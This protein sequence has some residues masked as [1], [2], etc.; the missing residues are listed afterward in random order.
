MYRILN[1]ATERPQMDWKTLHMWFVNMIY[2]LVSLSSL[3]LA[4]PGEEES[5]V[6]WR[7]ALSRQL[8]VRGCQQHSWVTHSRMQLA[9][10]ALLLQLSHCPFK[11]VAEE[12]LMERGMGVIHCIW[13]RWTCKF[14]CCLCW[15]YDDIQEICETVTSLKNCWYVTIQP[16]FLSVAVY[17][18]I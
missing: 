13:N 4:A 1:R 9:T 2:P 15:I 16:S 18:F 17:L 10:M 7:R 6:Q 14:P 11:T 3:L 8:S 5:V 12:G